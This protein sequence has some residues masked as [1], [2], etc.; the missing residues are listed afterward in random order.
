MVLGVTLSVYDHVPVSDAVSVSV[1]PITYEPTAKGPV[2]IIPVPAELTT[3]PWGVLWVGDAV[4]VTLPV[5]PDAALNE[6][7]NPALFATVTLLET[8]GPWRIGV[9]LSVYDHV[10]V[11]DAVSESVPPITYEPTAKVPVVII[12]VPAELTT[13]P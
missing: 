12:P 5:N 6:S 8:D 13:M 3:M 7:T 1:P 4:K 2:V 11:S 10:P 9:T